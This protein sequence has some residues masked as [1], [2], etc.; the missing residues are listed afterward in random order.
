[1]DRQA[2]IKILE[3]YFNNEITNEQFNSVLKIG[4]PAPVTFQHEGVELTERQKEIE[5]LKEI[6]NKLGQTIFGISFK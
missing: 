2:R 1:M 6:Y 5:S 3:L 4:F